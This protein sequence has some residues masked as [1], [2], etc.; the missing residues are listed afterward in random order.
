MSTTALSRQQAL[1]E[2]LNY[3]QQGLIAEAERRYNRLLTEAPGFI[4]AYYYL[5]ALYM[6]QRK[7]REAIAILSKGYEKDPKNP[8][9]LTTLSVAYQATGQLDRAIDMARKVTEHF[10]QVAEARFNLAQMLVSKGKHAEAIEEYDQT[11][12]INPKMANA[13][14]N[15]G[16][17]L[18]QLGKQTEAIEAFQ[19]TIAVQPDH[20]HALV[21]MGQHTSENGQ[22]QESLSYL[23][24]ALQKDPKHSKGL[25]MRG[26][27]LHMTSR[28]EEAEKSYILSLENSEP[29][30]ETHTLLGNVYRDLH[31]EGKALEHYE[32]ALELEPDNDIAKQNIQRI[33]GSKIAAWHMHMLA[34]TKRNKAYHEALRKASPG[35][36][37][38]DIGT[39]SGLLAMMAAKAG[40][41]EVVGC[42]MILALAEVAEDIVKDNGLDESIRI[43]QKR[44]TSMKIG[45][46]MLEKA[47]VLVSEILD[48]GLLGEGVI[49][50]HRHALQYLVKPDAEVIP[51]K[52]TVKAVLLQCDD[53]YQ[54]NPMRTIEGF[55]L[56][57]FER[58]RLKE[59][60]TSITMEVTPHQTLSEVQD[61]STISFVNLPKPASEADPNVTELSFTVVEDGILHG[62]AFWFDLYVNSDIVVSSGP[63]GDM[64]HWNQAVTFFEEPRAVKA[65][66]EIAIRLMQADSRLWFEPVS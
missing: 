65:G 16:T 46:D 48:V 14:Y 18:Y 49:P 11:L 23:E 32:K 31:N 30:A 7:H 22:Y 34:D 28:L 9:V 41:E 15:K 37:V 54:V 25:R 51:Q 56:S 6:D 8:Q 1:Q 57:S 24:R 52:A 44:S 38:L 64:I 13:L 29:N 26:M 43:V 62:V 21:N 3:H 53:Y 5:G 19:Q 33:E 47:D 2:A 59:H 39:G 58:F 10:P 66:E 60:Y 4:E 55:D 40:A 27:I 35:K 63:G 17:L 20:V 50:T 12:K 61:V 42:E 45:Q 36:R